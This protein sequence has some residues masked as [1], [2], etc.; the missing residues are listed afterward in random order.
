MT[1]SSFLHIAL[2]IT[3]QVLSSPLQP[4]NSMISPNS[5]TPFSKNTSHSPIVVQLSPNEYFWNLIYFCKTRQNW[6][7]P[8]AT[9]NSMHIISFFSPT[10]SC[11]LLK[12]KLDR[13]AKIFM[14]NLKA[15]YYN[16]YLESFKAFQP[17]KHVTLNIQFL[18][19][20]IKQI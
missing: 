7:I 3:C 13:K 9:N 6:S 5:Q 12:A 2:H 19:C 14:N 11:V 1:F 8:Q 10:K 16:S 17:K 15:N 18:V 20:S 4:G